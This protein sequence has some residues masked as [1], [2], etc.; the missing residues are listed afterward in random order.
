MTSV[1]AGDL[2]GNITSWLSGTP[3]TVLLKKSCG[4]WQI[5]V[6]DVFHRLARHLCCAAVKSCLPDVFLPY[7]QVGMDI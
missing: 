6:G 7:G 2:D 4:F 3:L 5:A 1:L